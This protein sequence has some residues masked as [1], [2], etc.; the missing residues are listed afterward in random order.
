MNCPSCG[1][2][3]TDTA[4]ECK[5]GYKFTLNEIKES[6]VL[7]ETPKVKSDSGFFSP[8]RRGIQKGM[9]GGLTMMGIALV[10]FI[11]GY[12]LGYIFYYPPILFV[13]GL[14]AFIKGI[15]IGNYKGSTDVTCLNFNTILTLNAMEVASNQYN[16]PVCN[17]TN[18]I[19]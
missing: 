15:A 16:C 5:C 1:L 13:I 10:W 18:H 7:I 19:S 2:L 9:M 6:K 4:K 14:Y 12:Q 11:V 17:N 3:N 8:E